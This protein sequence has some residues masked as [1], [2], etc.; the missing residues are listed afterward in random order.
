MATKTVSFRLPDTIVKAIEA[1]T[2]A[3]GKRKTT[4]I[5]EA[6]AQVYGLPAPA[7]PSATPEALQQQLDELKQQML[8][9][10]A[11]SS[12]PDA[13]LYRESQTKLLDSILALVID[14]VFMCDRR[15]RFT[16][17]N[18]AGAQ[19]WRR[20]RG[21][22]LGK[23]LS[24]LAL[25]SDFVLCFGPQL[26][27]ALAHGTASSGEF[28]ISQLWETRH[29]DYVLTPTLK[30]DRTFDGIIGVARDMTEYKR[31]ESELRDW[32]ERY[33]T[34]LELTGDFVFCLDASTHA[35]LETNAQASRRLGYTRRE[36]CHRSFL[37]ISSP[38]FA[39]QY[40]E[41]IVPELDKT[42][43]KAFQ[44][45]FLHK[46]GTEIP[47]HMTSRLIEYG[48]RLVFQCCARSIASRNSGPAANL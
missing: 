44:H 14:P 8:A 32:Q 36:L 42:G 24:E 1:Q 48:E 3:T 4:L 7:P 30:G 18:P 25:P 29:Y 34:L 5:I 41:A 16:Y 6:L 31:V 35:I 22:L 20:E 39:V 19:M 17:I 37:D 40:E 33:R 28:S 9:L 23:T 11:R 10:Q 15:G 38:S 47:V 45:C 46:N 13:E 26:E 43:S 27:K 2:Q 12:F 21:Q